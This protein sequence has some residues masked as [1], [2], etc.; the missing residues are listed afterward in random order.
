MTN[1]A[2]FDGWLE[3]YADAWR[4]NDAERIGALFSD[5]AVYRW[6]PYDEG[7]DVARGREAIVS[8]WLEEPDDPGSWELACERL[9]VDGDLGVARCVTSYA[10]TGEGTPERASTTTSS[11]FASTR[12]AA[13]STSSSTTCACRPLNQ[14]TS[15]YP[16]PQTFTT[17]RSPGSHSSFERSRETC[18]SSVR[19][20]VNDL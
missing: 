9:A 3:R 10:D 14:S 13:A 7:D 8:A 19:V 2:A 6:H 16:T 12:R 17:K 18:E 11:S 20:R 5:D 4:S 15:L 1:A